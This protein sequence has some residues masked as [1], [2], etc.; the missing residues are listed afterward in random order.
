MPTD[1][2]IDAAKPTDPNANASQVDV[3]KLTPEQLEANPHFQ[4]LKTK[5]SAAHKGMDESNLS[6]KELKAEVAR[7]KV[8]A[9]EEVKPE[10]KVELPAKE[11]TYA[12][13]ED[14]WELKNAKDIEVY[15]DEEFTKDVENGIPRDYALTTAKLRFQSNPDKARLERQQTMASGTAAGTRILDSD[16]LTEAEQ[17]GIT[18]GLYSKEAVM[19]QRRLKKERGQL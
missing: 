15:G 7:L 6:K 8:L 11:P 5:Y 17:A 18:K 9:G 14:I 4:D 19:I 16:E 10:D 3:T 13:K 1:A 2:E 12:T